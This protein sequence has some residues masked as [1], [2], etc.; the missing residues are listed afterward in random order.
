[1]RRIGV[2]G[3]A[4]EPREREALRRARRTTR[5]RRRR[6]AQGRPAAPRRRRPPPGARRAR[7]APRA[8]RRPCAS[9]AARRRSP[10]MIGQCANTGSTA[11]ERAQQ[12]QVP[13]GVRE[14]ILAA[15]DVRDPEVAVVDAAREVER[16]P[17]VRAH[18]HEVG[19]LVACEAHRPARRVLNDHL[20]RRHAKADDVRLAGLV[21]PLG[22]GARERSAAPVVAL[23]R[24]RAEAAIGVRR[25]QQ[26][27]GRRQMLLAA[28]ALVHELARVL[29]PE[30]G[31]IGRGSRALLPRPSV[32]RRCRRCAAT[33]CPPRARAA[34]AL[35]TATTAEPRCSGPVG[36][37]A[38]RKRGGGMYV[39][40]SLM[41]QAAAGTRSQRR[42]VAPAIRSAG[43]A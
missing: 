43:R 4:A 18:E 16:R 19:D 41:P 13:G 39:P 8:A 25:R 12:H 9:R 29:Q 31:E 32:P 11:P 42:A 17:S 22:L 24:G 7:A 34:S 3:A 38:K 23:L 40:W 35:A 15:H 14:V 28:R 20:A 30:P 33:S 27:L 2:R 10:T 1:M 5:P 36:E 6:P 26:L 21:A 37:G